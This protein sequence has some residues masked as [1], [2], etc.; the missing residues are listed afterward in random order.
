MYSIRVNQLQ[1]QAASYASVAAGLAGAGGGEGGAGGSGQ[2]SSSGSHAATPGDRTPT[3]GEVETDH[4]IFSAGNPRVE[5][6]VGRVHLYRHLAP[7]IGDS[8]TDAKQKQAAGGSAVGNSGEIEPEPAGEGAGLPPGRNEQLCILALPADMGFAELCT[9]MGAYFEHV[10]EVRLVRREGRSSVCLVLLRF[11]SQRWADDFFRDFNGKP[12]C[13]LEPELLCRLV[14]VRDVECQQ[15]GG[16]QQGTQQ[17]QQGPRAPPGT[18]ELPT[19]PVCLERLDEHISGIVTTVC[20]HRFHNECLRQWGDTSCPV[21]R[22]CQH[23]SATT[24]N[25]SVCNTSADLWICLI[26]GHVGCGRYRGSHAALHWQSSGHGYA[27]ELETQR[28]WDYVNDTYVHRLIQSKTD[29]KL[30]EVPSPAQHSQPGCSGR[31][32]GLGPSASECGSERCVLDPEMEEAMVLSKLDA[33]ATEYNHL[34]VTQLESQRSYFEGLLVRQRAEAEVEVEAAQVAA[35]EART[36][37]QAA[38]TAAHESERKRRQAESK[39]ADTS[40]RLV[41]AEEERQ[42]LRQL[43]DTLLANQRDFQTRLKAAEEALQRTV[44]EKDAAIRDLQEQ[45]RDLMVFLEARQTIEQAGPAGELE[46]ATV[47]PVPPAPAAQQ[48]GS[49]RGKK[50]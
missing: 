17:A 19:C 21:C 7:H 28:V 40:G 29:G 37:A 41:K 23:S 35:G 15:A 20:N 45:V 11:E 42:F 24:S 10:R 13:L 50:R 31:Q 48:R 47:L 9:F 32:L 30:V 14:F 33:L 43:N 36:A 16:E 27:L 44:A 39:L 22:Y 38:Q 34:L 3:G 49:R 5:H 18:T 46:G 2:P 25:C 1:R 26:C 8:A 4:I 6:M 12:F